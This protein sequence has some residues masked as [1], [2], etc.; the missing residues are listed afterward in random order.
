MSQSEEHRLLVLSVSDALTARHPEILVTADLQAAPGDA[1]PP[2][3]DGFRPDI[4]AQLPNTG[5]IV[6]AEAKTRYD[7][8]NNHT[9]NQART[10]LKYLDRKVNGRFILCASGRGADH[11]KT[12]L[13]F[14]VRNN[15]P[16]AVRVQV[17]DGCDFW[18]LDSGN[19][20]LWHLD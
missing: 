17:F 3:I 16:R 13:R 14:L 18:T 11:A 1:V 10:F 7:I 5:S 9:E 6:I 12:L 4:Y 19:G 2:L 15:K 20:V 8:F